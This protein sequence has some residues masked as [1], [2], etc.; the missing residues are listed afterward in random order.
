[1]VDEVARYSGVVGTRVKRVPRAR[2]GTVVLGNKNGGRCPVGDVIVIDNCTKLSRVVDRYPL[3]AANIRRR[4]AARS[5][6][7]K[8][9]DAN[10]VTVNLQKCAERRAHGPQFRAEKR[11]TA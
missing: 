11:P 1:M 8:A 9:R 4:L 10:V 5:M 3:R 2:R 6:D 7:T